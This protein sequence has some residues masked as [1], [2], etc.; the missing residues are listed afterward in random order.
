MA[1]REDR[2]RRGARKAMLQ[3]VRDD[4]AG[5][6]RRLHARRSAWPCA[7]SRSRARCGWRGPPAILCCRSIWKRRGTGRCAAG[8]EPRFRSRSAPWRWSSANRCRC[9]PTRKTRSWSG[10]GWNSSVDWV[11][12]NRRRWKWWDERRVRS[13]R[14]VRIVRRVRKVRDVRKVQPCERTT[15]TVRTS[16]TI[17]ERPRRSRRDSGRAPLTTLSW[18]L[19]RPWPVND[20]MPTR[21]AA[22]TEPPTRRSNRRPRAA[23]VSLTPWHFLYLRPLPQWHKSLRPV[24]AM[25]CPSSSKVYIAP[26]IFQSA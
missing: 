11:R 15:R 23:G 25:A 13:V 19:I 2:R 22:R 5:K 1:P 24:L 14:V 21:M 18:P 8:I 26:A 12:W 20:E 7:W 16:R 4:A 9:L 10:R 3:L 6:T 17:M